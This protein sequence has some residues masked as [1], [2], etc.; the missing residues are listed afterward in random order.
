MK[1]IEVVNLVKT[2]GD[3]EAVKNISF[4]VEKDSF[5]AFL[6]P[7]GAG[8]STTINII[9]TLLEKNT[10]TVKV[11]NYEL[12]KDDSSIRR[13]IGVV[14]QGS[15]LDD[16]LTVKENLEV[17]GSFYDISKHEVMNRINEINEYLEILPFINQR[18][19]LLSGGQRR[20]ADIARALLNWPEILIL[21]EPT[22]GLDPKSRKD[23]WKLIEKLRKEKEITIFLTTHYME[24]ALDAN[25][26]VIIDEGVIVAVGSSEELR[27]KYSNDRIKVIPNNGL[28]EILIKDKVNY[29]IVNGTI[30]II[31]N[32][33][34]DGL[35]FIE[36]Y[37]EYIKEFEILRGNMDD[38]FLN[39]TGKKLVSE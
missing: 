29:Y 5:F 36:K 31:I 30:N 1:A 18:Y 4:S 37:K 19:G 20:K 12:G 24:E 2:Y 11:A 22:T 39:I 14:F 15:M 25:R 6:G 9:A 10:G 34:F 23:I 35:P 33:C 32:S 16:L 27:L 13:K 3:I 38:V 28:E 8:K 26:V 17:R 7:N 21:D